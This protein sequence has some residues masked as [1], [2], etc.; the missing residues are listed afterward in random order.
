MWGSRCGDFDPGV[1][2]YALRLG[3]TYEKLEE[4]LDRQWGLLGVSGIASAMKG[5]LEKRR[6]DPQA[7][8]AVEMFCYQIRKFVGAFA[9]TLDGL[10]T[11]VFTGGIRDR[12]APG[13]AESSCGLGYFGFRLGEGQKTRPFRRI[14]T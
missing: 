8:Q 12:P 9:A 3:W 2:L 6:F 10:D 14:C 11:L 1:I 5:L 13:R 4:L 7:A